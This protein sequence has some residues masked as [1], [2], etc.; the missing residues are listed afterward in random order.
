MSV[1]S[2]L[3]SVF[4]FSFVFN[5]WAQKPKVNQ[6]RIEATIIKL[7]EYGKDKNG[8]TNRV[9][10]SDADIQGRKYVAEL[11][12]EAGLDVSID[13]AGN[14]IGKRAGKDPSKKAYSVRIPY[15]YGTQWR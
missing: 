7:A 1:R 3:T 5:L 2:T 14:I 4:L 15:R 9:A 11:M 13:Y 10:F 12:K 8:V 6:D